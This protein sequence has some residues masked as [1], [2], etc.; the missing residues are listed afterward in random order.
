[1]Y[2]IFQTEDTD[3]LGHK[4]T[5]TPNADVNRV[6]RSLKQD[7]KGDSQ[8]E[9]EVSLTFHAFGERFD[10][11]LK[12]NTKLLPKN[13]V[14]QEEED[15]KEYEELQRDDNVLHGEKEDNES[16]SHKRLLRSSKGAESE[17]M[18][19]KQHTNYSS[20]NNE[21]KRRRKNKRD[22][23]VS[24]LNCFYQGYSTFHPNSSAALSLCNGI[25]SI[26]LI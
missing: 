22:V 10:L 15:E 25:V 16:V 11:R 14:V 26:T 1:M 4:K 2:D 3:S 13:F 17:R 21:K 24:G 5:R 8:E 7:R 19:S 6:R 18:S 23:K 9:Q 20:N 12:Q